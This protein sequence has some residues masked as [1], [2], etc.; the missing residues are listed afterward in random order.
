MFIQLDLNQNVITHVV[1][2]YRRCPFWYWQLNFIKLNLELFCNKL[3]VGPTVIHCVKGFMQTELRG[4]KELF[5]YLQIKITSLKFGICSIKCR[6]LLDQFKHCIIFLL[7]NP[8][9]LKKREFKDPNKHDLL[10]NTDIYYAFNAFV[11]KNSSFCRGGLT[12]FAHSLTW[13]N[14]RR[15]TPSH[16]ASFKAYWYCV[17]NNVLLASRLLRSYNLK[18]PL[19]L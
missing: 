6:L 14:K 11:N 9:F 15:P 5:F 12:L 8:Y 4:G 16:T 2:V 3:G 13:Q 17:T 7:N 1:T 18:Q 19:R 10:S